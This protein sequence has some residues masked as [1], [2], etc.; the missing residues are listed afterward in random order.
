MTVGAKFR[1]TCGGHPH[2]FPTHKLESAFIGLQY[3]NHVTDISTT[4]QPSFGYYPYVD[5]EITFA[6][7]SSF[8]DIFL[9]RCAVGG[10]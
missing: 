8:A 5:D 7:L 3:F 4:L 9:T 1:A 6:E 10:L 2:V